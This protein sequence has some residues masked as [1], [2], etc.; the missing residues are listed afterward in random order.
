MSDTF[1]PAEF[2]AAWQKF[3]EYINEHTPPDGPTPPMLLDRIKTFLEDDPSQM[4][5]VKQDFPDR[6]L[7]NLQIAFDHFLTGPGRSA[8]Q[9]GY[10][11]DHDYPGFSISSILTRPHR[12]QSVTEGPVQYRSVELADGSHMQCV[13]RGLYFIRDG[14]TKLVAFIRGAENY[15]GGRAVGLEILCPLTEKAEAML[16]EL[17]KLLNEHNVYRGHVISLSGRDGDQVAFRTLPEI[18]RDGIV[19][20][21]TLL[22]VIERNTLGFVANAPRLRAAGRHIK[23]GLLFHGPPGA[24]KTLTVMYLLAQMNDRTRILLT[25]RVMGL[26]AQACQ[27]ARALA[28]SVIVLEDVDLIAEERSSDHATGPLLFELLNEMDGLSED[29]DVLFILST[30]RADMLEPA[31]AARPGRIDQAIEFP[32]PDADC[33]KRL[34]ELYGQGLDLRLENI[35]DIVKRTDGVSSAFIR[36]LLRKAA[37]IAAEQTQGS[38][39]APVVTDSHLRDALKAILTEGGSLTQ[40]MLGVGPG[41]LQAHG[42]GFVPTKGK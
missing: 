28:P 36:E 41:G 19:L 16:A 15:F 32:L 9:T 2:G 17:R 5:I 22:D 29:T 6:D 25:G 8:E 12:W 3:I 23:R 40:K 34:I 35:D 11:A 21:E 27:L 20:P 24:G 39:D 4:V 13:E 37:L 18:K 30:N 26:V 7:P 1:N 38:T 10:L 42:F 33:R 31:L 14:E